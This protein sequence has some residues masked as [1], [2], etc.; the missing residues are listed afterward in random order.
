MELRIIVLISI[1]FFVILPLEIFGQKTK[2]AI[3]SNTG[4]FNSFDFVALADVPYNTQ[5]EEKFIKLISRINAIQ[6]ASVFFLGDYKSSKTPCD[7]IIDQKMLRYFSEF[8]PPV[9]YTPGDNEWTDCIDKNEKS[10]GSFPIKRL[11]LIRALFFQSDSSMGIN[12]I[13]LD[14]QSNLNGFRDYPENIFFITNNVAF[15]TVHI[16]GS[17]NNLGMEQLKINE[18]YNRAVADSVWLDLSFMR[19]VE[20]N[21][22]AMVICIHADMFYPDKGRS[23]FIRFLS[24]LQDCASKY[25]KPILLINGDSHQFL[26]DKPLKNSK[27][28]VFNNFTRVQVFGEEEV[29]AVGIHVDINTQQ[30]FSFY[31]IIINE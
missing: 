28:K 29:G 30:I 11:Q 12:K 25:G 13:H 26:I 10:D 7:S 4:E 21:T 6:P 31:Q 16:V 5:S 1:L 9:I 20:S 3:S 23:G 14:R 22:S 24:Q 17:N 2:I 15:S 19:A 27:N 18:Y 8:T